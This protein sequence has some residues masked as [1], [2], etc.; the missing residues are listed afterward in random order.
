M[1]KR[2]NSLLSTL[3][4][5]LVCS[6]A[7]TSKSIHLPSSI[8]LL[9]FT[10]QLRFMSV[11]AFVTHIK[12]QFMCVCSFI[13]WFVCFCLPIYYLCIL[14][15]LLPFLFL[16]LYS[17]VEYST[18]LFFNS[19]LPYSLFFWLPETFKPLYKKRCWVFKKSKLF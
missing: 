9:V 16:A 11:Y 5:C 8:N 13:C 6:K 18:L 7:N 4:R 12:V 2:R 15:Y 10:T 3:G 1:A 19:I 14:Y 17:F